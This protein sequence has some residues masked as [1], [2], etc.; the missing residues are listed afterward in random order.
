MLRTHI[1]KDWQCFL[2][3]IGVVFKLM[4]HTLPLFMQALVMAPLDA[5][6]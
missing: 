2:F 5:T 6:S 1:E 4:I 3:G